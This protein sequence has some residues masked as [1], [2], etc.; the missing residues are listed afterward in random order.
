MV[1]SL[2]K[3]SKLLSRKL[4]NKSLKINVDNYQPYGEDEKLYVPT[5]QQSL[6]GKFAILKYGNNKELIFNTE[7]KARHLLDYF[8]KACSDTV[9]S[10][11]I[12]IVDIEGNLK[13][14]RE[15]KNE[16]CSNILQSRQIYILVEIKTAKF[17]HHSTDTLRPL[18]FDSE[19]LTEKFYKKINDYKS[20][21][22]ITTDST[23]TLQIPKLEIKPIFINP[24]VKK[25][26]EPKLKRRNTF[27]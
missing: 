10:Q 26:S 2:T 1:Q 13:E 25:I 18:L 20:T 17:R 12:D 22:M 16:F 11:V 3:S 4:S 27:L 9:T 23:H 7:C 21:K 15:F 8:Y 5:E 14:L 19:L 24:K 6:I